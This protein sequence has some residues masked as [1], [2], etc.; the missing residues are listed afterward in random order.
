MFRKTIQFVALCSVV[1]PLLSMSVGT[2]FAGPISKNSTRSLT[3]QQS[4]FTAKITLTDPRKSRSSKITPNVRQVIGSYCV[5]QVTARA[6]HGV[7]TGSTEVT[8][9][10]IVI[11][12][13]AQNEFKYCTAAYPGSTVC[14]PWGTWVIKYWGS[15]CQ[16]NGVSSL[17]CPPGYDD[18][19]YVG[20]NALWAFVGAVCVTFGSGGTACGAPGEAYWMG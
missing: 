7:L 3:T 17:A 12:I 18:G 5:V 16:Y 6:S 14:L 19:E 11:S 9:D 4:V 2:T 13:E 20:T 10:G 1:L 8:C 15:Y